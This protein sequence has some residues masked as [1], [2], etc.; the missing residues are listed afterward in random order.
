MQRTKFGVGLQSEWAVPN[1]F[2]RS[3]GVDDIQDR[4][5]VRWDAQLVSAS[6]T[7]TRADQPGG[8][9]VL[10]HS[11]EVPPRDLGLFGQVVC[12][13]RFSDLAAHAGDGAESVFGGF[14][15]H[16]CLV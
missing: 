11:R 6:G 15:K 2:D 3:D 16:G 5:R 13:G 7:G 8:T 10:K 14:G 9:E 4:E 12:R 1:A